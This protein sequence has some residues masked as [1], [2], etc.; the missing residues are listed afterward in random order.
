MT[1]PL[2]K[3]I[4]RTARIIEVGVRDAR[5]A[6]FLIT[7]GW[8]RYLGL[9]SASF[10][11]STSVESEA[12]GI[13]PD[14]YPY[15]E[16]AKDPYLV[17][18]NNADVLIFSGDL[19]RHL[20]RRSHYEHAQYLVW[21]PEFTRSSV[22]AFAGILKALLRK[23]LT[24]AAAGRLRLSSRDR[25]ALL[26]LRVTHRTRAGWRHFI[27]PA[28]LRV[29]R[30]LREERVNYLV[31]R[32]FEDFPVKEPGKDIDLLV[33]D[34]HVALLQR[35]TQ[36]SPGI[37]ECEIYSVSGLPGTDYRETAHFP[38]QL[39]EGMLKRAV[40][41]RQWYRVPCPEDHFLGLAFH[42]LYHKGEQSGIPSST[43]FQTTKLPTH[44][45]TAVLRQMARSLGLDI[46]ITLEGLNEYLHSRGLRP[47]LD[48]LGRFAPSNAWVRQYAA[49]LAKENDVGVGVC[50]FYIR[51]RAL[52]LG[53]QENIIQRLQAE[54]FSV[55]TSLVLTEAQR[56][57]LASTVR[58]GNWS[59]G[60]WPKSGGKPAMLVVAFD[61]DPISPPER[62]LQRHPSLDNARV[63]SIK[64]R[65][66]TELSD[67]LPV[68]DR[69][70][71]LHSSDNG[72]EA[73]EC[74]KTVI[75]GEVSSLLDKVEGYKRSRASLYSAEHAKG[76]TP[77]YNGAVGPQ[78]HA[79]DLLRSKT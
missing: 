77:T 37:I 15:S 17:R 8:T 11:Q 55:L 72:A 54:G 61:P 46:E 13:T 31:L 65:I 52:E 76:P 18:K 39:A 73:V 32:W 21:F 23:R 33:A 43:A 29:F 12:G 26:V 22:V 35:V 10:T 79:R 78:A 9:T 41:W 20:S 7:A 50:N 49:A 60:P 67:R 71:L 42:A 36:E 6:R 47:N 62:T 58:G 28:L 3:L 24:L 51:Q 70:N 68:D 1:N 4:P 48:T 69:C 66:R 14:F 57:L 63:L 5:L 56:E 16:S 27:S 75:P 59:R 40:W 2:E 30:R 34:D 74:L 19:A 64:K 38:P 44:D 25:R 45:Y 53:Y